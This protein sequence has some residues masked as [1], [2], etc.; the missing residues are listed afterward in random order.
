MKR[1]LAVLVALAALL[2]VTGCTPSLGHKMHVTALLGDSAGV[3]VG[4]DVGILGVPV[5][6]I[7]SITPEGDHVRVEMEIDGDQPVPADAG[8]AV[9]ARSVA[10]DRYIEL[11]PVYHS[12]PKM[13]DGAVIGLDRTRTP[14]DFDQVLA[15]LKDFADGI[16]GSGPTRNA[17]K[18]FLSVGS[19]SLKGTG[20]EFNGAVTSLG[21]AMDTVSARRGDLTSTIRSLDRLTTA[22]AANRQVADEFVG[23]VSR[24]SSMLAAE[25]KNFDRALT[26]LGE[27]VQ[28]VADFVHQN[29]Q[30]FVRSLDQS[31]GLMRSLMTKRDQLTEIVRV[32]PLM[33]QNFEALLTPD[34]R[35]RVRVDPTVL[36]PLGGLLSSLCDSLPVGTCAAFGPSLLNLNNLLALLGLA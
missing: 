35:V 13:Q 10:T 7:T 32:M 12:G 33:L 9:V 36:V 6:T 29:R 15:S 1:L 20:K 34:N 27:A 31:T 11:T 28:L 24:A 3:F 22:I 2:S 21:K 14:V 16:S 5:G 19:R 4:N 18:R 30:Q 23:Q 25:R 17:I 26:S 8:A